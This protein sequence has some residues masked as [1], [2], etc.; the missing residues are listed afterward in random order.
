MIWR[1]QCVA[2]IALCVSY[3]TTRSQ[4]TESDPPTG[5]IPTD[6]DPPTVTADPPTTTSDPDTFT[7]DPPSSI[8]PP[9]TGTRTP[10][11]SPPPGTLPSPSRSTPRGFP[12]SSPSPSPTQ[13]PVVDDADTS[14]SDTETDSNAASLPSNALSFSTTIIRSPNGTTTSIIVLVD[15]G[16]P[17]DRRPS[18]APVGPIE[19]I[20]TF[21]G[22]D[23]RARPALPIRKYYRGAGDNEA[24]DAALAR[25]GN[26]RPDHLPV[27]NGEEFASGGEER[28][29]G[30]VA[31]GNGDEENPSLPAMRERIRLL[32]QQVT[33]LRGQSS[34]PDSMST[35][36]EE[37][38]PMYSR[39]LEVQQCRYP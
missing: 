34:R 8:P 28:Y 2:L 12:T 11:P 21:P 3:I 37:P 32:Q 39:T 31:E 30:A 19:R 25:E 36:T 18:S 13:L 29:Y 26:P 22:D 9:P 7:S 33:L 20:S 6:I 15:T 23:T 27:N 38:P 10:V 5:D 24:T 4:F 17:L 1:L 35:P 14:L 16:T